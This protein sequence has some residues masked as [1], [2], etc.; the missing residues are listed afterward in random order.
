MRKQFASSMSAKLSTSDETE[1]IEKEWSLFR[2]AII[3]SAVE[4]CG[5]KRLRVAGIARNEHPG[6][7]R[8]LKK[9]FEQRKMHSTPCCRTGRHQ[10]C[11]PSTL[12][13]EKLQLWQ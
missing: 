8:M 5:Q 11:N 6:G 1:D 4:C 3:A 13:C 12:R 10:I 9:P 7:T 2:T